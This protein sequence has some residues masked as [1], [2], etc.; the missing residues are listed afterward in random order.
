MSITYITRVDDQTNLS[1]YTFSSLSIGT[2]SAGRIVWLAV[3]ADSSANPRTLNSVTIGGDTATEVRKVQIV[4]S[5]NEAACGIYALAVPTGTTTTVV[6][7]YSG[8]MLE[9]NLGVWITDDVDEAQITTPQD[10][11]D[12]SGTNNLTGTLDVKDGDYVIATSQASS[13]PS[14]PTSTAGT[15]QRYHTSSN[16]DYWGGDTTITSDDATYTVSITGWGSS[17]REI[18][19]AISLRPGIV[20]T[21]DALVLTEF[22]ANVFYDGPGPSFVGVATSSDATAQATA[23]VDIP[24]HENGDLLG[25]MR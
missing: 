12:H 14:G 2:A 1:T 3:Q 16:R 23:S 17:I 4:E 22:P 6:A 10:E 24:P 11:F 25:L 7:S 20:A 9:C 5:G 13:S 21:T 18:L 15:T 8:N 19:V